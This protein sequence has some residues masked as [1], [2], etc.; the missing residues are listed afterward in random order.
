[1]Q[2]QVVS[3]AGCPHASA[4]LVRTR[5]ALDGLGLGDVAVE[6]V[7]VTTRVD[8]A[9]IGFAGSPTILV[10]GSDLLP[11]G[12]NT[13]AFACRVY[14]SGDGLDGSPTVVAITTALLTR[15]RRA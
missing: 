8:T 2:V 1:M 15:L 5:E 7:V 10:D 9:R 13:S 6:P 3:I 4:A 12:A 11:T 14:R